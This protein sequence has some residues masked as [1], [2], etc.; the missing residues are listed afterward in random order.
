MATILGL[1]PGGTTGVAVCTTQI[2]SLQAYQF[3]ESNHHI[4]LWSYLQTLDPETVVCEDFKWRPH[5]QPGR[6]AERAIELVSVEYIGITRLWT[7][8]KGR[9][10]VL[11]QPSQGKQFWTDDKLKKIGVYKPG[12]P[13]AMDAVR[14]VLY[15]VSFTLQDRH[16]I[17]ML[18]PS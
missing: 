1:D 11:Q 12:M 3:E 6:G 8:D 9:E 14:H 13:H 18:K 5:L 2:R 17:N 16:Y 10:L 4:A 15:Y 7:L